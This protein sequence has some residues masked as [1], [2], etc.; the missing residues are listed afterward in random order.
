MD[1]QWGG[2]VPSNPTH[3]TAVRHAGIEMAGDDKYVH[4]LGKPCIYWVT[5]GRVYNVHK[6][7]QT[8]INRFLREPPGPRPFRRATN[9]V[10]KPRIW[11]PG[12]T[13]I[14]FETRSIPQITRTGKDR[15]LTCLKPTNR[16]R[17]PQAQT[18]NSIDLLYVKDL[19]Y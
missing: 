16:W 1:P 3:R 13:T 9:I 5:V 18:C 7:I 12:A 19:G 11:N 6:R 10:S 15:N 8:N 14:S 17:R 4:A 2:T